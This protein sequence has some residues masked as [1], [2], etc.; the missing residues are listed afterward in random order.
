MGTSH[1][2]IV[3]QHVEESMLRFQTDTSNLHLEVS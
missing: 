1:N 2:R 3:D